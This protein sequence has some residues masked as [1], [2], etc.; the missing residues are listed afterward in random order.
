MQI[1]RFEVECNLRQLAIESL[2]KHVPA[3][4]VKGKGQYW[5]NSK[6]ALE[7]SPWFRWHV[8]DRLFV[9]I[10][11]DGL[12]RD[13]WKKLP[14]KP[15][16]VC[17]NPKNGNHQCYWILEVPVH[18][19]EAAKKKAA[20]KYLRFIEKLLDEKY[21]GDPH[22]ARAISKNFLHE[23]WETEFVHE[24]K[25]T[26]LQLDEGFELGIKNGEYRKA[27]KAKWK[28][29]KVAT[30]KDGKP[31]RHC[32]LF[33]KIRFKAMREI[34]RYKQIEGIE[35]KDWLG[36]LRTWCEAANSFES[37]KGDLTDAS[38]EATAKSIARWTWYVYTIPTDKP[39]KIPMT[40]DQV[41]ATQSKAAEITNAKRRGSSEAAIKVAIQQLKDAE[42][43]P[44][45]A[46]VAR[47]VGLS[48]QNVSTNY[49]HLFD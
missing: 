6:K 49:S 43:K 42:K 14:I 44:T 33:D 5:V 28:K 11:F 38:I 3:M 46:A 48:R 36:M 8:N 47:I 41:K 1:D 35:Y 9:M 4:F 19:H 26:L 40:Q 17:Y 30:D 31:S 27:Q 22:F 25:F 18:C 12:G 15:N 2:H 34:P 20:Y 39:I 45:K 13:H 16:I 21:D 32:T 24:E 37:D 29:Q 10:D 23:S 7:E